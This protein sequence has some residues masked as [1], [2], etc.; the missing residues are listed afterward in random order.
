[1]AETQPIKIKIQSSKQPVDI[2]GTTYYLDYSDE[3]FKK[4][5]TIGAKMQ[6][7]AKKAETDDVA[8]EKLLREAVDLMLGEGSF[9]PIYEAVGRSSLVVT[10]IIMQLLDVATTRADSLHKNLRRKYV[11]KK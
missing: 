11:G 2:A 1:M 4:Y 7:E 3:T 10:D 6:A 8:A 5:K 9:E